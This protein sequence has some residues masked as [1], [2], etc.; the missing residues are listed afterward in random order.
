MVVCNDKLFSDDVLAVREEVSVLTLQ[1][2]TDKGV[3]LVTPLGDHDLRRIQ[4]VLFCQ[5]DR[6]ELWDS[7]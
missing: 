7:L 5:D 4:D 2:L 1:I 3:P 6:T